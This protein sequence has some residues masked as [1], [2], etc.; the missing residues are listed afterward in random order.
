VVVSRPVGRFAS[1]VVGTM[2]FMNRREE[3]ASFRHD[4]TCALSGVFR[5]PV[6]SDQEPWAQGLEKS[7]VGDRRRSMTWRTVDGRHR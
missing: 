4:E 2:T 3:S 1:A 6:A 5:V 7:S